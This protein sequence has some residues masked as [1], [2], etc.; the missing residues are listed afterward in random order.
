MSRNYTSEVAT[1]RE[2]FNCQYFNQTNQN[3]NAKYETTLLKP[4]F[5]DPDKW[6]LAINRFRVPVSTIPLTAN[7]I[8]L[9]KWQVGIAYQT[10]NSSNITSEINTV[11]Q[12]NQ[13]YDESYQYTAIY[14]EY[15]SQ[16]FSKI[17]PLTNP[18]GYQS[19]PGF[20]PNE[21]INLDL[22]TVYDNTVA[23]YIDLS[24]N[25]VAYDCDNQ[26]I[27]TTQTYPNSSAICSDNLG[28]MYLGY[29]TS[30]N[31]PL[32]QTFLRTNSTTYN[33][34]VSIP[35]NGVQLDQSISSMACFN[36]LLVV[37]VTQ[38]SGVDLLQVYSANNGVFINSF[39]S[40]KANIDIDFDSNGVLYMASANDFSLTTYNLS[41]LGA[42][43]VIYTGSP[44]QFSFPISINGFDTNNNVLLNIFQAGS[45]TSKLVIA[46]NK[47]GV[48][49]YSQEFPKELL[50]IVYRDYGYLPVETGP[51][52]IFTLQGF[53]NKINEAFQLSYS[54]LKS[55]VGALFSPT[56]APEIVYNASNNLFSLTCEGQYLTLNPDGTK[57]YTIFLNNALNNMF[58]FPSVDYQTGYKSII[59]QNYGFNAIQGNGSATLPQFVNIYQETS[60]IYAFNDLTRIIVGTLSI[61][62][63]GDGD[64]T[65]FTNENTTNNKTINQITDILPD[66]STQSNFE[67]VIYIPAGILRWYN[68]YAQQPF[69]KID[70]IFYY[71]TKDGVLRPLTVAPNEYFSCKLEFK[72][73]VGDF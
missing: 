1:Q 55:T 44:V 21:N 19:L 23:Y 70:L 3:Q 61:P 65:H 58:F 47:F 27:L 50:G 53:L 35:L 26:T 72:K 71:E 63:S 15:T 51:Y 17:N 54:T 30:T 73:G 16:T 7:N 45:Q 8:P 22:E 6:Q 52:D 39:N 62:V 25:G 4:F 29:I 12:Y 40:G 14:N 32:V 67:P 64:G 10:S 36:N 43:T 31:N 60:T 48:A 9:N 56:Q 41:S 66:T 37:A 34:N 38:N 46:Y 59:I 20:N 49:Q 69:T 24:G 18:G 68:L 11:L 33:T 13:K 5:N 57:Q 2:Y 28:N 42:F